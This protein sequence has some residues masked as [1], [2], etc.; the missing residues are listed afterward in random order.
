LSQ[1]LKTVSKSISKTGINRF[2]TEIIIKN[3]TEK[4]WIPVLKSKSESEKNENRYLILI[5]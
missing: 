5:F 4:N 2:K 3:E 1:R